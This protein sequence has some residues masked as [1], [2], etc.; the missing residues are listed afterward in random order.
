MKN[1]RKW[2]MASISHRLVS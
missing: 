2:L 1:Y